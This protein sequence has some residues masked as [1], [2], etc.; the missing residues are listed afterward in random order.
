MTDELDFQLRS[1]LSALPTNIEEPHWLGKRSRR[2]YA[3]LR[4]AA[5]LMLFARGQK[6]RTLAGKREAERLNDLGVGDVDVLLLERAAT[7]RQHAGQPA[8]PGGRQDPEDVS[9]IAAALREAQEEVGVDPSS[10]DV[11]T[12]LEPIAVPVSRHIVTP[13]VGV[14]RRP[15]PIRVVDTAESTRVYRVSVAD[16]VAPANRG[17][18]YPPDKA[19]TSPVFDVGVLQVWGFTAGL[20]DFALS[21]LGWATNWDPHYMH[22]DVK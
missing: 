3:N 4:D 5:V 21:E 7:L 2:P 20:L 1:K 18:F 13:V 19:Y 22:I 9:P 17:V 10:V 8:F 14:W 11:L 16:L 15:G 6:P 12:T